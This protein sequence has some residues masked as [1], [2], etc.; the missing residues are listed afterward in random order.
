MNL[1]VAL[2]GGFYGAEPDFLVRHLDTLIGEFCAEFEAAS[3]LP[4][5]PEELKHHLAL[6]TAC[7]GLLW[8]IDA[9]AVIQTRV[10]GHHA[11]TCAVTHDYATFVTE[12]LAGRVHP[13]YPPNNRLANIVF[14]GTVESSVANLA[15]AGTEWLRRLVRSRESAGLTI[16]GPAPSA[17]ERIKTRWRWHVLMKSE[18]PH[19]LTRVGRYFLERFPVPA[20]D[21]L[22]VTFDRDPVTLL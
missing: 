8:M 17:V 15:I 21:G 20:R 3:G 22:R 10:P 5:D 7:S 11:V 13:P 2:A 18:H 4:L 16:V 14:S 6:Q 9:P 1:G 19:E 12:E